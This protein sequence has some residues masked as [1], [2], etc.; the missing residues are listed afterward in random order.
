MKKKPRCVIDGCDAFSYYRDS[1][2]CKR[3]YSRLYTQLRRGVSWMIKR[4]R[5]IDSWQG[6]LQHLLGTEKIVRIQPRR[7]ARKRA[8]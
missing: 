7:A 2:L 6:G 5:Q 1:Q 8:A 4:A 3:C